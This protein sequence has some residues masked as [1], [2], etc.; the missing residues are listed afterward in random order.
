VNK[1]LLDPDI[2]SEIGKGTDPN[3]VRN[4]TAYRN[5]FACYTISVTL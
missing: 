4:A 5:A 3:I 2:L 1:C